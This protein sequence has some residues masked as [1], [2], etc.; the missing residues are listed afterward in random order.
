MKNF[1][2]RDLFTAM[3]FWH[4]C[5]FH[6]VLVSGCPETWGTSIVPSLTELLFQDL[7]IWRDSDILKH[8]ASGLLANRE[9]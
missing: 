1:K 6:V 9:L 3:H 5:E 7:E 2:H 8:A 4:L